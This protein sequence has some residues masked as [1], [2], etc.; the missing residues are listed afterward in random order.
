MM[1]NLLGDIEPPLIDGGKE[2]GTPTAVAYEIVINQHV[3]TIDKFY[4]HI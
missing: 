1:E 3:I 4:F 2:T